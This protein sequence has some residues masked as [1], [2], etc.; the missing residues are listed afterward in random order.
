MHVRKCFRAPRTPFYSV[1]EFTALHKV[2]FFLYAIVGKVLYEGTEAMIIPARGGNGGS[3]PTP[4]ESPFGAEDELFTLVFKHFQLCF[5][6]CQLYLCGLKRCRKATF[7]RSPCTL[8]ERPH[9]TNLEERK[10]R[11]NF[12]RRHA[13]N[14]RFM[15]R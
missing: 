4:P 2:F 7:A 1:W 11:I 8:R 3:I 13:E 9:W 10:G 14:V 6:I 5:S 15:A 12:F